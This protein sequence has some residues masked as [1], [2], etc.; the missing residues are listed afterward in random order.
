MRTTRN[1]TRRNKNI[2]TSKSGHGSNNKMVISSKFYDSRGFWERLIDYQAISRKINE[3]EITFLI[4]P[5]KD[6]YKYYCT[7][8]DIAYLLNFVPEEDIASIDLIIFRQ[9]KRKEEILNSAWGRLAYC[10]HIGAFY[11]SAA[12]IIEAI[13]I[14]RPIYW[15][16]SL[17]PEESKELER[18][19]Q[20]GHKI[21]Q[22]KRGFIIQKSKDSIR[23]TQLYRTLLHEIGHWVQY[24]NLVLS[25][26]IDNT[27]DNTV[28]EKY[29]NMPQAEKEAFAHRYADTIKGNLIN[30]GII[31]FRKKHCS[32]DDDVLNSYFD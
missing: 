4:E 10:I 20:D 11:G 23:A 17:N 24:D 26:A 22:D 32:F 29:D 1:P 8:E 12:V 18:L 19:Q 16:S 27:N 7:V 3:H 5:T 2:G 9:S 6:N 14:N 31:P 13:D 21:I 25:V 28:F 15:H 30:D